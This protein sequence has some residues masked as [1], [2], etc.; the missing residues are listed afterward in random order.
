MVDLDAVME[1]SKNP[2]KDAPSA[3]GEWM[4]LFVIMVAV[5]F[6][7]SALIFWIYACLRRKNEERGQGDEPVSGS[8]DQANIDH[9]IN[10]LERDQTM[11]EKDK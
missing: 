10:V 2:P 11:M 7:L 3:E 9:S 5:V 4:E 1:Q 8:E 6:L